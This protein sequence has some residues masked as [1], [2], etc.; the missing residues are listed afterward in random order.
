M[1]K[2]SLF[3]KILLGFVVLVAIFVIVAAF[4]PAHY[5]VKRS[6]KIAAPPAAVF[7]QVDTPK[8]WEGWNPWF[9]LDPNIKLTYSGPPS[10][11][12]ASYQ[13]VGNNEVGEGKM[14]IVESK[15][16]ELVRFKL[17]FLKPMEATSDAEF[18]FKPQ[19]DQTEVTWSMSGENGFAGKAI[20]V[21]MSM[22][23]M[24]GGPFEKGLADM[25]A[26]VEAKK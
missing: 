22:D 7:S 13:W 8:N 1:K 9:K 4:Q 26:I 14:T 21:F 18:T 20:T 23:K 10:G 17:H 3:V 19:G 11:V 5:E 16:N 25:K 15:P 2:T 6:T 24:I 12:G